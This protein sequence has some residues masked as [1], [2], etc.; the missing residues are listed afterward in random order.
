[1]IPIDK[2]QCPLC[3]G[4][5]SK[6]INQEW[7]IVSCQCSDYPVAE[8]IVILKKGNVYD[9]AMRMIK[10]GRKKDAINVLCGV[11]GTFNVYAEKLVDFNIMPFP[12]FFFLNF[13]RLK[14]KKF[15]Q[16]L[17]DDFLSALKPMKQGVYEEYFFHKYSLDTFAELAPFLDVVHKGALLDVGCGM[18]HFAFLAQEIYP[19]MKFFLCDFNFH[20][21]LMAKHFFIHDATFVCTDC[22]NGMPFQ[23]GLFDAVFA[24]D[25]LCTINNKKLLVQDFERI[26]DESGVIVL[27]H[28]HN[29]GK[30]VWG[31][32]LSPE[33][34][35]N[36]FK[37]KYVRVISE[38]K[39]SDDFWGK[40]V[41]DL[42]V[43]K[44]GKTIDKD[45]SDNTNLE[46]I[47][48]NNNVSFRKYKSFPLRKNI[49]NIIFN[50][51]YNVKEVGRKIELTR[52]P[53]SSWMLEENP[54]MK[55]S[56]KRKLS[57][58]KEKLLQ[59]EFLHS[60]IENR[61]IIRCPNR[62]YE[63]KKYSIRKNQ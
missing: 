42:T 10:Q 45:C 22:E 26:T 40:S 21:L 62:F 31:K 3:G 11:H 28:L 41:T 37:S 35:A 7:G 53:L 61:Y 51:L 50:P 20:F 13:K 43:D 39:I 6:E 19:N 34:Y 9:I 27:S 14:N 25:F 44:P 23:N 5:F 47:A 57:F 17:N 56:F 29:K 32:N 2:L 33:G 52:K 49:K 8:G 4:K 24:S 15:F 12:E 16:R 30:N 58:D 60:M 63:D 38:K 59:K 55:D 1:M 36:L 54:K 18:G 48:S 46:L